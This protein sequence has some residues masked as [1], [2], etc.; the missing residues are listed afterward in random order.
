MATG[1]ESHCACRSRWSGAVLAPPRR[2]AHDASRSDRDLGQRRPGRRGCGCWGSFDSCDPD[3]EIVVRDEVGAGRAFDGAV[4]SVTMWE[5]ALSESKFR[6]EGTKRTFHRLVPRHGGRPDGP[7]SVPVAGIIATVMA[8]PPTGAQRGAR[9]ERDRRS[10]AGSDRSASPEQAALN[11]VREGR[12]FPSSA[13]SVPVR[14]SVTW[15]RSCPI[16][17][18]E[19]RSSP[20]GRTAAPSEI[21]TAAGSNQRLPD[22]ARILGSPVVGAD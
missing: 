10:S 15:Y 16:S 12:P 18:T 4:F 21:A 5:A 13:I 1:R 19:R 7:T 9:S 17:N 22:P 20:V 14:L 3:F 8:P 11:P 6:C 2:Q